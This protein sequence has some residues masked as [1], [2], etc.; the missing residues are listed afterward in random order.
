LDYIKEFVM[1]TENAPIE[2][3]DHT[4]DD[5]E[6]AVNNYETHRNPDGSVSRYRPITVSPEAAKK[7]GEFI[8]SILAEREHAKSHDDDD[9]MAGRTPIAGDPQIT[10]RIIHDELANRDALAKARMERE[11]PGPE[12]LSDR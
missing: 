12:V 8:R 11:K 5:D 6:L 9:I 7:T 1:A 3:F 10:G 2:T 4:T